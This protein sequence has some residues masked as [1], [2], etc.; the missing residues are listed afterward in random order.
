MCR[1]RLR[2]FF[3]LGLVRQATRQLYNYYQFGRRSVRQQ[4]KAAGYSSHVE[5]LGL[6]VEDN[7]IV[8]V[9]GVWEEKWK[10]GRMWKTRRKFPT[11]ATDKGNECTAR[12][13]HR[14]HDDQQHLRLMVWIIL[15][16]D[17][18]PVLEILHMIH[19]IK[20]SFRMLYRVCVIIHTLQWSK[21][22]I[23]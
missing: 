1:V 8:Q 12:N 2:S 13:F 11:W 19:T 3:V 18:L 20:T 9:G 15:L 16:A 5:Q 23:Q 10:D 17:V 7:Q 14:L 22:K 6:Q 4:Q 21:N